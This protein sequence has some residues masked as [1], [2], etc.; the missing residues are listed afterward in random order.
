MQRDIR[1]TPTYTETH[2]LY[3]SI[4]PTDSP[5][6]ND[7]QHIQA[8]PDGTQ[9]LF[10][11]IST[12]SLEDPLTTKIFQINLATQKIDQL[13]SQSSC[14]EQQ[15]KYSPDGH[16][17]ALLSDRAISGNLQLNILNRADNSLL[18]APLVK[19]WVEQLQWSADSS[20][21]L[22][23]VAGH[24]ADKGSGQGAV[25]TNQTADKL[26]AWM[27]DVET[28]VEE[29][30]WRQAW[31]Y[32]VASNKLQLIPAVDLNI[33]QSVWCGEKHIAAITSPSPNEEAWYSAVLQ[34]IDIETG[35]TELLH[36]PRDQLACLSASPS[37]RT[38][39]Y[40][41]ALGSDRDIIAGNLFTIDSHSKQRSSVNSHRVDISYTEWLSEKQLLA[42]GHRGFETHI[43]QH[44]L[45][46]TP[47]NGTCEAVWSSSELTSSGHFISVSAIASGDCLMIAESFFN[48]PEIGRMNHGQYQC[49][50]SFDQGYNAEA[51]VIKSAEQISWTAADGLEIQGWLLSPKTPAPHPIIMDMHGGPVWQWRPHWLGRRLHILMLVKKGYAVFLPNPR[52]SAGRGQG[53]SR[54]VL[55]DLGGADTYDY[56]SGIDHLVEEGLADPQR[57]GVIGHSYGGYMA[58]W[59][60]SQDQRFA[61]AVL[62]APMTNYISQHLLSNISHFVSLFLDDHYKNPQGKYLQRSPV[63]YAHQVTTPT[64][65]ICGALDRCTPAAE[66]TQFHR[67]L[68]ENQVKSVLVNYPQEGHGIRGVAERI[69]Y[70]ARI[71]G[72]IKQHIPQLDELDSKLDQESKTNEEKEKAGSDAACLD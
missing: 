1:Q 22:L 2:H 46:E 68:L 30:R 48:A 41:E 66:A 18:S 28:G 34:L 26:P 13:S 32:T 11:G 60:I 53:Y 50:K 64:L 20:R 65:N 45:S 72:W 23:T 59:L 71:L 6:I 24:G 47:H 58:A 12:Q 69:D 67:A 7:A 33:W 29:Y 9:A 54:L 49:I 63:M 10:T 4:W 15:A 21:I 19:G 17:I 37:G 27:P 31:I 55:G 56:L 3:R 14:N 42:A 8:S 35:A 51:A 38:I 5:D 61:A 39:A 16:Y 43:L 36:Q 52:G 40:V 62:S 57:L 25:K 44:Q 70:S